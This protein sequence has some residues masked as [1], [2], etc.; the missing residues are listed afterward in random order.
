MK[1]TLIV[2]TALALPHLDKRILI[3]SATCNNDYDNSVRFM[4]T[5]PEQIDEFIGKCATTGNLYQKLYLDSVNGS[6]TKKVYEWV[7]E[8][9][10]KHAPA[11]KTCLAKCRQETV[12]VSIKSFKKCI[13]ELGPSFMPYTLD[14]LQEQYQVVGQCEFEKVN[15]IQ[16]A[17][18]NYK[19]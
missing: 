4:D 19:Q 13:Q 3:C 14:F 15:E 11:T 2:A 18:R 7:D 10:R 9:I 12:S 1:S 16:V 17:M 6:C 5:V 8:A